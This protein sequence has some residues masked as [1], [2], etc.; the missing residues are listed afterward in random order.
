MSEIVIA[1][2]TSGSVT[3][4][5]PD[6]AGTTTLTLPATTSDILT[7]ET[8]YDYKAAENPAYNTN[9]LSENATW[10]NTSTG[11]VWM[12][13][14]NLTNIN[15][16][17]LVSFSDTISSASVF[18][19]FGDNSAVA[20]YQFN[21]SALGVDTGG[22]YSM[23][24]VGGSATTGLIGDCWNGSGSYMKNGSSMNNNLVI[25]VSAWINVTNTGNNW[26]WTSGKQANGTCRRGVRLTGNTIDLISYTSE[27]AGSLSA[28][29]AYGEWTHICIARE[30]LYVNGTYV[31]SVPTY[32]EPVSD[33]Y[34]FY[35]GANGAYDYGYVTNETYGQPMNGLID[36]MRVFNRELLESEVA[37]LYAEGGL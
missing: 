13:T 2:N 20:L 32:T 27:Y 17:K 3:I 35:I 8:L 16:W 24:T 5:A 37:A 4:A 25:S 26:V 1:G 6:V 30:K 31:G 19:I 10:L 18:D 33:T 14:N 36:Q 12:C 29:F 9:P 28:T 23:S 15:T 7:R 22:V 11:N 34:G 21:S